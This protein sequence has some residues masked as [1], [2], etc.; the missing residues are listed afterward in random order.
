MK[1]WKIGT[2]IITGFSAIIVIALILGGFAYVQFGVVNK[3]TTKVGEDSLPSVYLVGQIQN[4]VNKSMVLLMQHVFSSDKDEMAAMELDIQALRN[5]NSNVFISYEKL[6]NSD[7]ERELLETIKNDRTAYWSA[8]DDVLKLSRQAKNKEAMDLVNSELK[9]LYKKYSDAADADVAFNKAG[10][11]DAV[12]VV[13]SSVNGA[14]IGVL[15]CL[16]LAL[17]VAV[18]IAIAIARSITGPLDKVVKLVEKVAHG[19]L[20]DTVEVNSRD[21]LGQMMEALNSMVQSLRTTV[22]DIS[23]AAD[24]VAS[25]SQEMSATSQQLSQ[26]ATEQSASAEESTSAMEEMAASIMQNADNSSQTDKIA[27]AAAEDARSGGD[28]VLKTV[29]AMKEI[30]EKIS[31]IEEIARKTDL[32]ALNAAVEAARA[33]EHGKGFAVVAS[34]VRKLAERSQVAAAEISHLTINGVN[35][36]EGAGQL[37]NKLVP[38]IRKTASLV[39]EI[40]AASKEQSSGVSQVNQAIQQL[41]QVIQQNAAA[42]EQMSATAE[43]LS[44][45]AEVLQESLTFFKLDGDGQRKKSTARLHTR[46]VAGPTSQVKPHLSKPGNGTHVPVA[47]LARTVKSSGTAI[48]L[49]TNNGTGDAHDLEFT[50]Y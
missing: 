45:Q 28:A 6:V 36:A 9:P 44:S 31:I 43:E 47:S 33:G 39:Q 46:V 48:D 2:R 15:I 34:E 40:A 32:L 49:G 41:D 42:S 1:N 37:L 10:G 29:A 4:N 7:K 8:F 5:N 23:A 20:R 26:G 24:N 25:G 27:S 3:S 21:E 22:T 11:E 13:Q 14:R 35:V 50:S 18:S 38:D 16:A 30:A 19:D 17:V 12:K